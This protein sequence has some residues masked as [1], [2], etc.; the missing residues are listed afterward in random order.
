MPSAASDYV[1]STD[2]SRLDLDW[3]HDRLSTDAYWA[4]GRSRERM[5]RAAADSHCYGVY[6]PEGGQVGFARLVTDRTT[7]AWLSDVYV[8]RSVRGMGLSKALMARI[9]DDVKEWK[10]RRVVLATDDA[11][12]LYRKFGFVELGDEPFTFMSARWPDNV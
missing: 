9:M 7:F 3:I 4:A 8:D 1:V 11:A 10:L 6:A 5:E 2:P 12:E